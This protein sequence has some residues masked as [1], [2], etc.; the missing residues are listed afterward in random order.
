MTATQW[1]G[2][3]SVGLFYAL[4]FAVGVYAT[5]KRTRDGEVNEL[6][7]AGRGLPVTGSTPIPFVLDL[8]HGTSIRAVSG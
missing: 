2:L 1:Y 5:R 8:A 3:L 6:L 4:V 7:L